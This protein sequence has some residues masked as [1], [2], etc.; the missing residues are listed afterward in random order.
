MFREQSHDKVYGCL[1]GGSGNSG[2]KRLAISM[3]EEAWLSE[4]KDV[5]EKRHEARRIIAQ[6]QVASNTGVRVVETKGTRLGCRAVSSWSMRISPGSEPLLRTTQGTPRQGFHSTKL[7]ALGSAGIRF[8][9]EKDGSFRMCIDYR[10]LN[11]LTVKNRYPLLRIDDLFD[12]LQG[13]QFFLKI[14]IRSGYHQSVIYM[15]HKSLQ[16]IFSQ[17][18]LNMRQHRWIELFSDYDCEIRYH[19]GKANVDKILAAQKEVVDEFAVLQKG[20]DEIIEQRSDGTLYYLDRIWVPLKGDAARDRQ[21]SYAD[22]RR[23]PLEFS[24]G[25]Y[26][27]LKVSPWKGMVCF[28]KKGNLAPRFVGPFKIIEK[29]G[30]VAYRLDLPEELNGVHDT[31]HVSNLKKC[32]ADPTLKV[33]LHEIQVDAKLNFVEELVEIL[34][35]KFKKLKRSRIAIVKVSGIRNVVL[36]SR[37]NV[38]IR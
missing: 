24:V 21:K 31:F 5:I 22:K 36:K 6:N 18:E 1:K 19:P 25:D 15:D 35:R 7:I 30:P 37:G 34:E 32:L 3:V 26:V 33:P 12:L 17:K 9:R 14:D 20:L 10:E 8:L 28:G 23:K 2:G 16:H 13:S 38:N 29:V 11:M 4:K 27:L